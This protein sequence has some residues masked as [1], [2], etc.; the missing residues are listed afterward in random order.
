MADFPVPKPLSTAATAS[1]ES[2]PSFREKL[3][4]SLFDGVY[5]VD[6][7]RRIRYWNQGA[8][9]LTGYSASEAVGKYCFDNFLVHVDAGGVPMR[10]LFRCSMTI[11]RAS[12]IHHN[13]KN[14]LQR[15]RGCVCWTSDA[16]SISGFLFL[17]IWFALNCEGSNR[18]RAPELERA[19]NMYR[20]SPLRRFINEA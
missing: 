12:W 15:N 9:H 3:L 13:G 2:A 16:S 7:E 20:V 17:A 4:D 11:G 6:R 1:G 10:C 18:S 8:E 14:A 5:F 19:E